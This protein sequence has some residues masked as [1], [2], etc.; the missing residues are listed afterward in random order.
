MGTTYELPHAALLS[1]PSKAQDCIE[2]LR[3]H[4]PEKV[5]LSG[6]PVTKLAAVL[7][8]LYEKAGELRVLL[9]TRSKSLRAH[10]GQTAL[11]G[12][13]VDTTDANVVVTAYR[14]AFEEV[15]L[16]LNCPDVHTVC[17]MR[18]F[19]SSSKLFVT[20]IVALLSNLSIL[21]QLVPSEAE[22]LVPKGSKDWLYEPDYHSTSDI[23]LSWLGNST[24]RMHRFR[25][26]ASPI[27]GL[28]SDILIAAAEIAY[29]RQPAYERYSPGQ[30]EGFAP[31]LRILE[32]ELDVQHAASGTSTPTPKIEIGVQTSHA[33]TVF[34]RSN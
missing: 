8:L 16:P 6:Y 2:R 9:T 5:D 33:S 31:I 26:S 4:E 23:F 13:K 18:P 10:P 17:I 7:I 19:L 14:E 25:S 21:D 28:T 34:T 32:A 24:Y 30:L 1:L 27:K 3:L 15:G 12:G 22:P 29:D 11:P 20:P